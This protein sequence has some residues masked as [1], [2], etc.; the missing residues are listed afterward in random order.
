M[1]LIFQA[2]VKSHLNFQ[3]KLHM[4]LDKMSEFQ[5]LWCLNSALACVVTQKLIFTL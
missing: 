4:M 5:E 2:F 1:V 3:F